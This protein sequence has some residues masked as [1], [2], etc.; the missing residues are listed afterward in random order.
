MNYGVMGVVK[1]EHCGGGGG[2]I[3]RRRTVGHRGNGPAR[4]AR[5][6]DPDGFTPVGGTE[7][8]GGRSSA[9]ST[10]VVH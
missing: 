10:L 8:S 1:F 7:A 4:R 3:R 9:Q 5:S 2:S 6:V